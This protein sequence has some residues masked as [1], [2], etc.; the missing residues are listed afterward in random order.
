MSH[1]NLYSME[2]SKQYLLR[3]SIEEGSSVAWV[4]KETISS[5]LDLK[6]LFMSSS[7]V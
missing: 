2:K 3:T 5:N 7:I 4:L 6:H 1:G